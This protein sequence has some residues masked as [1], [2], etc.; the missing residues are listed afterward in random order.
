MINTRKYLKVY[1]LKTK[2]LS[3]ELFWRHWWVFQIYIQYNS[4][5]SHCVLVE[6]TSNTMG[7]SWMWFALKICHVRVAVMLMTEWISSSVYVR[8]NY[9]RNTL[10]STMFS[11][12]HSKLRQREKHHFN[13][14]TLSWHQD[15][16][17]N[18]ILPSYSILSFFGS[19]EFCSQYTV[20]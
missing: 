11:H 3:Q 2:Y 7:F 4:S 20:R 16:N 1:K 8:L 15:N 10:Y 9:W 12:H 17:K 13:C 14:F 6:D 5:P 18:I 19:L